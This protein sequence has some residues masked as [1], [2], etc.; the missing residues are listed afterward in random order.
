MR[1]REVPHAR[2]A[3]RFQGTETEAVANAKGHVRAWIVP[4]APPPPD[5][6]WHGIE[7]EVVHPPTAG[8]WRDPRPRAEPGRALRHRQR[9]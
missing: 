5:R 2:V 9:H 8:P 1:S 7:L 4:D 3:I 6:L